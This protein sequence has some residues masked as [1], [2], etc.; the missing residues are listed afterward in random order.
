M[1]PAG[2]PHQQCRTQIRVND[3]SHRLE[4][5]GMKLTF[6]LHCDWHLAVYSENANVFQD[7]IGS[8][9]A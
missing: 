2:I 9:L 8:L 6:G 7:G 1:H 3:V 4:F 5:E